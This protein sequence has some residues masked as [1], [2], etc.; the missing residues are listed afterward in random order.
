MILVLAIVHTEMKVRRCPIVALLGYLSI[1]EDWGSVVDRTSHGEFYL[2]R[3]HASAIMFSDGM[4][5]VD[6]LLLKSVL[7]CTHRTCLCTKCQAT[8]DKIQ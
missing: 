7:D 5:Q 4:V 2:L 3:C 8:P 1:I 6:R